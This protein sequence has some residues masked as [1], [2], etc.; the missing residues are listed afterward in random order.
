MAAGRLQLANITNYSEQINSIKELVI[1]GTEQGNRLDQTLNC[2]TPCVLLFNPD[3]KNFFSVRI[4]NFPA[5]SRFVALIP[6][7]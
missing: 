2:P 5:N 3:T 7:I 1:S 6:S 4:E